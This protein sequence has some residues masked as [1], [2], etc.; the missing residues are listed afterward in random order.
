ML[1]VYGGVPTDPAKRAEIEEAARVFEAAC[2]EEEGCVTYSLSWSIAEPGFLRLLEVW[3][4]SEAHAVHTQQPHVLE[5]TSFIASASTAPPTFTKYV[6]D[7][8][9]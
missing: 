8:V 6:V 3:E 2:L 7:V 4:P 9:S 5:W 1:Y